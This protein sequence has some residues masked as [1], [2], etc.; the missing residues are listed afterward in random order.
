MKVLVLTVTAGEGHNATAAAIQKS[1]EERGVE[2]RVLD[3]CLHINPG[4]YLLIAKGYLLCATNLKKAY[5]YV[6]GKL[7]HREFKDKNS[8]TPSPT[9]TSYRIVKKKIEKY[10]TEY[11][12]DAIVYTHVFAGALLDVIAEKK[13][14][15]ARTVGILT[16]F[17]PHPFWEETLRTDRV[18]IANDLISPS[19]ERKGLLR[20]QLLPIG[21]PIRPQFAESV[22]REEARREL[23]LDP[24]L[25]TL[26]LMGGSMGYGSL[27]KTLAEVDKLD[28][29]L[30]V[31][32]VCGRN[33]KAK[34]E[35]D[36]MTFQKKVLAFG[37]TDK[38][39]LLMDASDCIVSKPGG[40]TTSEALAKRLPM[41]I[42]N[43][44][45]GQEDR[46]AEFLLNAGVA[47]TLSKTA[48]LSDV[49]YQLFHNPE[50][51]ELMKKNIDLIRRPHA[52]R[53]LVDA[54]FSLVEEKEAEA[55][56]EK[57]PAT[58]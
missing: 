18:V 21:I 10:I 51:I 49:V 34:A 36:K 40:L 55:A 13:P 46:N 17:A 19:L 52:T 1:F 29:P 31:I 58:V 25:P 27:A 45:P 54:V 8:Y 26:L 3:T 4:L 7:E 50:R 44:I 33:E 14:L 38:I 9:R 57:D 24:N 30:Q 15:G 42:C 11:A 32:C 28:T 6:Y 39:S 35:I 56:E 48:S 2:C 41:I 23:G 53:D 43:P 12:P 37:Y 20:E 16:D 22:P 5:A 47:V